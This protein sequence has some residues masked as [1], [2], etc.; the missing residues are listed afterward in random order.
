MDSLG[1]V[2]NTLTGQVG[3]FGQII[4][5][6]AV[7]IGIGM[8]VMCA[9]KFRAHSTNPWERSADLGGAVGW[10]IASGALQVTAFARLSARRQ[11]SCPA[12]PTTTSGHSTLSGKVV[13]SKGGSETGASSISVASTTPQPLA[14]FEGLQC[15]GIRID[16]P[17]MQDAFPGIDAALGA[18]VKLPGRW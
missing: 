7:L 11:S 12:S 3:K 14:E 6:G 2:A 16:E 18:V 15:P 5:A 8:L 17:E 9:Y 4:G 1:D 10:L 13:A